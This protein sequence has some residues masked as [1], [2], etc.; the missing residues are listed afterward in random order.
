[1][2]PEN[3]KFEEW[4]KKIEEIEYKPGENIK[5]ITVPTSETVSVSELMERLL[6]VDIL[7]F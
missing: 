6:D 7:H 3:P 4:T 1:M 5:Y 2:D